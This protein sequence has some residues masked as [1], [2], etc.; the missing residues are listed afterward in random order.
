[1]SPEQEQIEQQRVA[2]GAEARLLLE[3]RL[4]IDAVA[5]I[6]TDIWNQFKTAHASDKDALQRIKQ[7][8]DLLTDFVKIFRGHV[9]TGEMAKQNLQ[10]WFDK[11]SRK[12]R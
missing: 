8:E 6:Q 7:R 3:N 2:R 10:R 9:E 5:A 11:F 1:M 4:F 12:K